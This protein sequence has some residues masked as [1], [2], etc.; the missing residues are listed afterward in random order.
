[1]GCA[2]SYG[3]RVVDGVSGDVVGVDGSGV[4]LTLPGAVVDV[5]GL[6]PEADLMVVV[7]TVPFGLVVGLGQPPDPPPVD[8]E[9][10]V[11]PTPPEPEL[12]DQGGATYCSALVSVAT[13]PGSAIGDTDTS[14]HPTGPRP[15][16]TIMVWSPNLAIKRAGA[17]P[18]V[19]TG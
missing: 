19:T 10:P 7:V 4:G 9:P 3:T 15:T 14:A 12:P 16:S 5:V 13:S 8:P 2:V 17:P 6:G 1:M 18:T 11:E